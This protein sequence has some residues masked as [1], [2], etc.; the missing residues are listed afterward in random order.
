M[1]QIVTRV[2]DG[3]STQFNIPLDGHDFPLVKSYDAS[4]GD[5][6]PMTLLRFNKPAV[7]GGS[8]S[9]DVGFASAPGPAQYRVV[10][11]QATP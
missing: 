10:T 8:G 7:E 4:T 2:G 9:L 1:A 3:S 6:V 5:A 11:S